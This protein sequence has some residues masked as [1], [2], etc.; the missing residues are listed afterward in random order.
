[1]GYELPAALGVRMAQPEGE[2]I[3]FIGDG[4][5][6]MNPTELVTALQE[7]LKITVVLSENH[8][9]QVIHRL[10]R[11]RS[12]RSFGNE[13]R[14]RSGKGGRLDGDYLTL[15][16]AQIAEGLGAFAVTA[17]TAA[18]VRAELEAARGREASTVIV[19]ETAPQADLPGGGVWW[20]VAPAEVSDDPAVQEL[21]TEYDID[22][23]RL[24]RWYG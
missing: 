13:F 6:L 8:G 18:E 12:G 19:V 17:T 10:Q 2:V 24:Q 11:M 7:Q 16:F 22:R 3:V 15:N 4:T 21:R 5:F 9:F 20:D 14:A 1:M 23:K